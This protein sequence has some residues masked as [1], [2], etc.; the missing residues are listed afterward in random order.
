MSLFDKEYDWYCDNCHVHMNDQQ[1]FTTV[2][3]KWICS[4]CGVVND[5]SENN[6]IPEEGSKGYVFE[7]SYD[8]G[9]TEKVRFTKT[10]EVHDFDGPNGKGS[11]WS[12]R[13]K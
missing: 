4:E 6:I 9:T 8:D 7:K 2:T 1:G 5:V 3:D 12:K 13:K 10:R 11:V